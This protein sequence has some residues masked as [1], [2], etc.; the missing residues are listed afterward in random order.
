MSYLERVEE[1]YD[2][3]EVYRM[4]ANRYMLTGSLIRGAIAMNARPMI[5]YKLLRKHSSVKM[6]LDIYERSHGIKV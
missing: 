4:L 5:Y 2:N 1:A 6:E 3:D